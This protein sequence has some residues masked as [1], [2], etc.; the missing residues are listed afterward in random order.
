MLM[1]SVASV[2]QSHDVHDKNNTITCLPACA[3]SMLGTYRR[4]C[5]CSARQ[6][7]IKPT[8]RA[9]RPSV[10]PS[11]L[12][13]EASQTAQSLNLR[14][15]SFTSAQIAMS[16]LAPE[17]VCALRFQHWD[18]RDP[19]Q[20]VAV[21]SFAS[22]HELSVQTI[23]AIATACPDCAARMTLLLS[24]SL[25]SCCPSSCA[26]SNIARRFHPKVMFRYE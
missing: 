22:I 9:A 4:A 17:L 8:P 18:Q 10:L 24:P 12:Q 19:G 13:F 11:T 14:L 21:T 25:T 2:E 1:P 15:S 3:F 5:S 7:R 26:G 23:L 20:E 6:T 16:P